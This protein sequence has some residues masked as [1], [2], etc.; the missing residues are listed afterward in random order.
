MR[1]IFY[2][3]Q[4]QE[5]QLTHALAS[6]LAWNPAL[7]RRFVRD[8]AAIRINARERLEVI[9]PHVPGNGTPIERD[10]KR[11]LPDA[12]IYGSGNWCV[13]IESKL[14]AP[15]NKGQLDRHLRMV[16]RAFE[17]VRLVVITSEHNP[18][19][20]PGGAAHFTWPEVF[21][22]LK[23]NEAIEPRWTGHLREYMRQLESRLC[24]EGYDMRG[25]ITDFDGVPFNKENPYNYREAKL[26]LDQM[27]KI[28]RQRKGLRALGVNLSDPGRPAITGRHGQAIWDLLSLRPP[29]A[30]GQFTSWPHLTLGI[31]EGKVDVMVTIP[32]QINRSQRHRIIDLGQ[33]GFV[34][35][36]G[37]IAAQMK[38][39]LGKN[40]YQPM[41]VMLQRHYK[42][43]RIGIIDGQMTF[44]L[45][46]AYGDEM[47]S[48]KCQST[49]IRSAF[50]LFAKKEGANIQLQ[51]GAWMPHDLG[52][53]AGKDAIDKVEA[54]WL[55]CRPLLNTLDQ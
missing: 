31:Q 32:H 2:Q 9:Q 38:R 36:A 41:L 45:R 11:S 54:A 37:E 55:S 14:A 46:T 5:N 4:Q 1:N 13:V 12:C 10:E 48:V 6:V 51:F 7:C 30:H 52:L 47:A 21:C 34:S 42:P 19:E 3:F 26:V 8:F 29:N 16:E 24:V 40:G 15:F 27:L 17:D 18:G 28:L 33:D 39:H 23:N 44:D 20:L 53:L 25:P 43:R 22:W 50:D 35:L 49:W